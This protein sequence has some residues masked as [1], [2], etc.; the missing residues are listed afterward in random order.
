MTNAL[1][2]APVPVDATLRENRCRLPPGGSRRA[3]RK[4]LG[5]S[6]LTQPVPERNPTPGSRAR[7]TGGRGTH[8]RSVFLR[9]GRSGEVGIDLSNATPRVLSTE[10]AESTALLSTMGRGETCPVV[11]GLR[12][13]DWALEEPKGKAIAR[14]REIRDEV[15]DRALEPVTAEGGARE[16]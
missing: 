2:A 5:R 16:A 1:P 9:S 3:S 8:V 4:Y 11:P 6:A 15:L 13:L 12:R 7:H 14:V 10:L